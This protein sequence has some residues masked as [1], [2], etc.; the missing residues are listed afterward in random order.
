MYHLS[1]EY[2]SGRTAASSPLY[3][4]RASSASSEAIAWAWGALLLTHGP[5]LPRSREL[6]RPSS[7]PHIT[8]YA[9][10]LAR[11]DH[12][13]PSPTTGSAGW[14][15]ANCSHRGAVAG[16]LIR[17]AILRRGAQ[18][19][20]R[21]TARFGRVREGVQR[22]F[23]SLASLTAPRRPHPATCPATHPPS[24]PRA[25]PP[26]SR[27][28]PRRGGPAQRSAVSEPATP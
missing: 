7:P 28:R 22:H 12:L 8:I 2:R 16:A 3:G 17:A 13:P 5:S 19:F 4:T 24:S 25:A 27:C 9:T 15:C 21:N 23:L 26:R 1:L 18:S 11:A 20:S 14:A 10:L 6:S